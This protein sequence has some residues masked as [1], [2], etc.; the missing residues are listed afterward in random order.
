ML[1]VGKSVAT[2]WSTNG[3]RQVELVDCWHTG[4]VVDDWLEWNRGSIF[5]G[6]LCVH[7]TNDI[8]IC[9]YNV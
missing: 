6:I 4:A 8:S 7:V 2:H 9:L 3:C 1:D 5:G